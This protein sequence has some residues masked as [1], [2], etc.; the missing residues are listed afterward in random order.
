[1]DTYSLLMKDHKLLTII[2]KTKLFLIL[3]LLANRPS[4]GKSPLRIQMEVSYIFSYVYLS[5]KSL[6]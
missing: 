6:F 1:M 2:N 3:E 5:I 4:S